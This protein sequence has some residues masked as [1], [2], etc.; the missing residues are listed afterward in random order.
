M[1]YVAANGGLYLR[2]L[3]GHPFDKLTAYPGSTATA[4]VLD[5][6][7][8]HIAYV[9]DPLHVFKTTD[10]G[11]SWEDLTGD[12][13]NQTNSFKSLELFQDGQNFRSA[14]RRPGGPVPHAERC[15]GQHDLEPVRRQPAE[16]GVAGVHYDAVSDSLIVGTHGRGA[17]R[18]NG[19]TAPLEQPGFLEITGDSNTANIIRLG[20][21]RFNPLLL[22]VF[23]NNPGTVPDFQVKLAALQ[24]ID[25]QAGAGVNTLI[26]DGSGDATGRAISIN[27]NAVKGVLPVLV[28]FNAGELTNLTIKGGPGNDSFILQD[29]PPVLNL[30]LDGGGGDNALSGPPVDTIWDITGVNAGTMGGTTFKSFGTLVGDFMN[31]TFRVRPQRQ[32]LRHRRGRRRDQR[33]GLL[34][35]R[36]Q[37]DDREPRQ[38]LG[39]EHPWEYCEWP[40]RFPKLHR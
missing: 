14:G 12:L 11:A 40:L 33:A 25:V 39:D 22:D 16:Y 19:A 5:P 24:Q 3:A 10:A 30:T 2:T 13:G 28:T 29:K 1:A 26:L 9:I 18:L 17:W 37:S 27:P 4:I 23:M 34:G 6:S 15:R 32:C 36:W 21:D 31:D 38:Q 8:W 20:I 35:Q 7:D